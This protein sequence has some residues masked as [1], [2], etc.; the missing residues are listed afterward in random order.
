MA[1]PGETIE[2]GHAAK[3]RDPTPNVN[4]LSEATNRRQDD[5]RIYLEKYFD[6]GLEHRKEIDSIRAH[7]AGEIRR[8]ETERLDSIRQVDVLARNTAADRAADATQAL[9]ATTATNAENLRTAMA[10]TAATIA[11]QVADTATATAKTTGDMFDAVIKRVASLEA[12]GYRGEG[13]QTIADPRIEKLIT[14]VQLMSGVT[15]QATGKSAGI[16]ASVV[17]IIAVAAI[18]ASL[19]GGMISSY[20]SRS[21]A[22]VSQ[23]QVVY[24]PSPQAIPPANIIPPV[25][26]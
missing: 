4:A 2:N 10:N 17:V 19:M 8:M 23:P 21:S 13:R 1:E 6:A 20:V 7:H 5:L 22:P 15:Q 11:K 3:T 25:A 24:L 18:A 9:A 12:A 14:D 26:R 16:S